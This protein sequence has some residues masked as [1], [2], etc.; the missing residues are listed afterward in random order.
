M[1]ERL[2]KLIR[3]K[4]MAKRDKPEP[5]K[6]KMREEIEKATAEYLANGGKITRYE[7]W[8][9]VTILKQN[10]DGDLVETDWFET[11]EAYKNS[12]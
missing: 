6:A 3:K 1:E 4:Q 7:K 9:K 2:L 10:L 11:V 8:G 5:P 12:L